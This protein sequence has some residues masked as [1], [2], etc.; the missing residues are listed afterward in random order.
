VVDLQSRHLAGMVERGT[1][2]VITIVF[3]AA[4]QPLPGSAVY[5]ATK[6]FVV[7]LSEAAHAE[8]KGTGV[9]VTAVCPGPVKTEFVQAAGLDAASENLHG[10]V[11]DAGRDRCQRSGER[12]GEGQ[13]RGGARAPEQG[14]GD[15]RPAHSARGAL[16]L[17]KRIWRQAT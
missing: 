4:F 15:H 3:T 7:S 2:A 16:P 9:A 17:V 11:L 5:A 13:A 10:G 1:G 6:A 14:R 12:R 8:L